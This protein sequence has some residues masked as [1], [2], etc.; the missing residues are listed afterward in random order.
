[1]AGGDADIDGG[2]LYAIVAQELLDDP[3]ADTLLIEG[4]GEEVAEAVW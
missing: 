4:G 2:R 3:E 1:M